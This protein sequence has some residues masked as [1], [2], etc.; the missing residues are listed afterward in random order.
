MDA[1]NRILCRWD[2]RGQSLQYL[3]QPGNGGELFSSQGSCIRPMPVTN[4]P[5]GIQGVP[6][7]VR[8]FLISKTSVNTYRIG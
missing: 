1:G 3:S 7:E 5:T 4:A 2:A 8:Y 6:A